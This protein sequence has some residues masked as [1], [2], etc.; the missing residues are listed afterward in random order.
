MRLLRVWKLSDFLAA[1]CK[2]VMFSGR[3]KGRDLPTPPH[4]NGSGCP[5]RIKQLS[6]VI[7]GQQ[8][9]GTPGVS[10][11]TPKMDLP[12]QKNT[13]SVKSCFLQYRQN[14]N[15]ALGNPSVWISTHKAFRRMTWQRAQQK[16]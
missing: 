8:K 6:S 15:L 1:G 9:S 12:N 3:Q 14:E 2:S 16:P 4:Y 10:E 7:P 5:L 13:T 11:K